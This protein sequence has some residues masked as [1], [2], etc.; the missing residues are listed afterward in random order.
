MMVSHRIV[1]LIDSTRLT[2]SLILLPSFVS[3]PLSLRAPSAYSSSKLR[4]SVSSG[5]GSMNSNE[6]RSLIPNDFR[7]R[8]ADPRFVRC[9][10][11]TVSSSS[12]FAKASLVKRRKHL[13]G[14]TRP[15]RPARCPAAAFEHWRRRH[16]PSQSA[17]LER[18][19]CIRNEM[20]LPLTGTT[21]KDSM[22]VRGLY[23]FCLTKP[24]SMT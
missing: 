8:M 23:E 6:R 13:P 11:A 9:I 7:R 22:P 3:S 16:T 17:T 1:L 2:N 19:G 5:G 10:S 12:S 21:V 18:D 15:A 14:P 20:R 24:G 4:R